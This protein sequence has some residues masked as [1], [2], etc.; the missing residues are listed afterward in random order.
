MQ[1][2]CRKTKVEEKC[3]KVQREK[4][5]F[6]LVLAWLSSCFN[7][8][9]LFPPPLLSNYYIWLLQKIYCY[10]ILWIWIFIL[11]YFKNP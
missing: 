9:V 5:S 3:V 1:F 6:A 11:V 10:I 4:V 2:K 7:A 8:M